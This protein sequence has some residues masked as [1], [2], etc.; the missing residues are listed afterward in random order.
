VGVG[1]GDEQLVELAE[2]MQ[3]PCP[4]TARLRRGYEV[5]E[6]VAASLDPIANA[7]FLQ[8]LRFFALR[9][10][11]T[12]FRHRSEWQGKFYIQD[13]ATG[14]APL[15]VQAV[16]GETVG[17][18]CA[19]PG[20]K[21]ILLSERMEGRGLLLAADRSV[22]RLP[23]LREN[24]EAARIPVHVLAADVSSGCIRP[25]TLDA[26]LLDV[27]C[28]NS[29]V[30]R[31]RPDV[32]WRYAKQDK[33]AIVE[34]QRDILEGVLPAVREG[35]RIVYSTCSID[36]D[37]NGEEVRSFLERHSACSLEDERQLYPANHHDG[38]YAARIRVGTAQKS[39]RQGGSM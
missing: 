18:L 3:R 36:P 16:P 8:D 10:P 34:L 35:G 37:E 6:S 2:V 38:A 12:F 30:A 9:R 25:A 1:L 7:P 15:M 13:P 20:G 17:D 28:S 39:R 19:A 23:K 33:T 4:V 29:G 5:P 27:P 11:G 14:L 22:P 31:R 24:F 32:R 21:T 26:A